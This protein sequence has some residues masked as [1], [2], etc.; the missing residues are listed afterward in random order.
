MGDEIAN[1]KYCILAAGIGSRNTALRGLHKALFPVGNRPVISII[2]DKIPKNV[3]IVIALGHNGTQIEAYLSE[4]YPGRTFEFVYVE[5][6]SGPGSGP[7]L[8]LLKCEKNMQCPFIFTSADTI[9]D[10]DFQFSS[11]DKNWVGVSQVSNNESH[12]YCLVRVHEG[13]VSEFFYGENQNA[14]AYTGIAGIL[15]YKQFWN[16]LKQENIIRGEH[17]VLDGLRSLSDV[18]PLSMTWLD[19]GN[20]KSYART[21]SYYPNDLVIEKNN[22]AIFVD[23]GRVIKYFDN[24]SKVKARILRASELLGCV[25][26]V[27]KIDNNMFCYKFH[28]GVRL[29]DVYDD[30]G[31]ANFLADY[32]LKFRQHNFEKGES[33]LS[34]C[35]KMYRQKTYDRITPFINTTLDSI[36]AINGIKVM[37]IIDLINDVNWATLGEKAIASRFHGDMQPEN[38]LSLPD[39]KYLYLDWRESFGDHLEIGDAYYDLGKLYHALVINNTLIL[40]G[41]YDIIV[42]NNQATLSYVIKNNLHYLLENLEEFC[43]QNGYD[44]SHV[45]L[46]GIL[47]YLN[48]AS[49][50]GKFENGK[51]GNFL[52][53]L[54]KYMLTK[55]L[56]KNNEQ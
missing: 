11:V 26:E 16:G 7:G 31:L 4:I 23:N 14:Y 22:E 33:F 52:F 45:Q 1:F 53:L 44:Y 32:H 48:I 56:E 5:N 49:L 18:S 10:E 43:T 34:D 30:I 15:D 37:P 27:T 42:K 51:Y 3:P 6:Y 8:S 19:T 20:E 46:V 47:N 54:G 9:V 40:E 35:D 28:E 25:P 41:G 55:L 36:S 29:S 13:L 2:I 21:K 50:Y 24:A 38:I 17:Q 39:G 12:E